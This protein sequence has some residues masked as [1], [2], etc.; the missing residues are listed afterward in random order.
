M[1]AHRILNIRLHN[2]NQDI[3]LT[4]AYAPGDHISQVE[5]NIFWGKLRV[6]L[7]QVPDRVIKL[8]GIDANGHIGRGPPMRFVGP[9]GSTRWTSNGQSL[10]DTAQSQQMMITNA[11]EGCATANGHGIVEMARRETEW[12]T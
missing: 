10:A 12:I 7:G 1:L 5:R 9:N 8:V 6:H 2:K 4:S 11:L 3:S